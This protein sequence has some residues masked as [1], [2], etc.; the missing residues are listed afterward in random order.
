MF[1]GATS[2]RA[3]GQLQTPSV[4]PESETSLINPSASSSAVPVPAITTEPP[5][6]P[7]EFP[8]PTTDTGIS[9]PT[10]G[11]PSMPSETSIQTSS[12][13]STFRQDPDETVSL[14][15]FGLPPRRF[16]S[17]ADVVDD[18]PSDEDSEDVSYDDIED[19]LDV[20]DE[21]IEPLVENSAQ[22]PSAPDRPNDVYLDMMFR[23]SLSE[24][25]I[26]IE[27]NRLARRIEAKRE[28]NEQGAARARHATLAARAQ[29][30]EEVWPQPVDE[31][32]GQSVHF[33][34]PLLPVAVLA[35]PP[36]V[37]W[38]KG[39]QKGLSRLFERKPR[40]TP[41][42]ELGDQRIPYAQKGKGKAL[43]PPPKAT[44]PPKPNRDSPTAGLLQRL[45][46][47]QVPRGDFL[48]MSSDHGS[49]LQLPSMP[50]IAGVTRKLSFRRQPQNPKS[51]LDMGP[52]PFARDPLRLTQYDE[53]PTRVTES[54]PPSRLSTVYERATRAFT[55][56]KRPV[57]APSVY[58]PNKS[59]AE[60]V[61]GIDLSSYKA[62]Q[63][64]PDL[65]QPVP[66]R[67]MNQPSNPNL[68]GT[69]PATSSGLRSSVHRFNP[70]Q[71]RLTTF[72]PTTS[73]RVPPQPR[74]NSFA[75]NHP[76]YTAGLPPR[77][78][79]SKPLPPR[80]PSKTTGQ[81][82]KDLSKWF[83]GLSR[84]STAD[85]GRGTS[86]APIN[87]V[88]GVPD[89]RRSTSDRRAS[90]GSRSESV[91]QRLERMVSDSSSQLEP[92]IVSTT[93]SQVES[94]PARLYPGGIDP[95]ADPELYRIVRQ[96]ELHR[97]GEDERRSEE[98][99]RISDGSDLHISATSF[100]M[101]PTPRQVPARR[102]S[103]PR[104]PVSASPR[105][106]SPSAMPRP[107]RTPSPVHSLQVVQ[108]D[109]PRVLVLGPPLPSPTA[110]SPA[111]V[112]SSPG[113][114][115]GYETLSPVHPNPQTTPNVLGLSTAPSTSTSS[116]VSRVS[117][118]PSP[119]RYSHVNLK[120]FLMTSPSQI[121]RTTSAVEF[122]RP[123]D[124]GPLIPDYPA[125]YRDLEPFILSESDVWKREDHEH[126]SSDYFDI[127]PQGPNYTWEKYRMVLTSAHR[128]LDQDERSYLL[129]PDLETK[130]CIHLF[131]IRPRSRP[132]TAPPS[133][134]PSV[135]SRYDP[136]ITR[137]VV[138]RTTTIWGFQPYA[139][140]RRQGN[141]EYMWKDVDNEVD[142]TQ[143]FDGIAGR[144]ERI[145][146]LILP[147]LYVYIPCLAND[148]DAFA[149]WSFII[150]RERDCL[151]YVCSLI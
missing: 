80:E 103:L 123:I 38:A 75:G 37:K 12:G 25:A 106:L 143:I 8:F 82:T 45:K 119:P 58:D 42:L 93:R 120:E 21:P 145:W 46:S 138:C 105:L 41:D 31:L 32:P 53:A 29:R 36:P 98:E 139:V 51:W 135:P 57:P 54:A 9:V 133:N 65:L 151:V 100:P 4:D 90:V 140:D 39:F 61:L 2:R 3:S 63:S 91:V 74:P 49:P 127:W 148:R 78:S 115:A 62:T 134:M 6:L 52:D 88:T 16:R 73:L 114:L 24:L 94:R 137:R 44:P 40:V 23:D 19:R 56:K 128:E 55:I 30:E 117:F 28:E 99:R 126:S 111:R 48:D 109:G 13:V 116:R 141:G 83:K 22:G 142:V 72:A 149:S 108:E 5:A 110:P 112:E 15:Y 47:K 27:R 67:Y 102:S 60:Q 97:R 129:P 43:P 107:W 33:Q 81:V 86:W 66:R 10:T 71:P 77:E 26:D 68:R 79:L 96:F 70:T 144:V 11:I 1:D 76:F 89:W 95:V 92:P 35:P 64:Y 34:E 146:D 130:I 14:T 17:D 150:N 118:A 122:R 18:A 124:T 69:R 121:S 59:K 101:P 104:Q 85:S 132:A 125:S 84:P 131:K 147:S 136:E 50:S 113:T 20:E 7:N 87:P